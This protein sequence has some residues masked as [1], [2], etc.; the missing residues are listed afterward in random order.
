MPCMCKFVPDEV[1][2]RLANNRD[3]KEFDRNAL[4]RT[5]AVDHQMRHVRQAYGCLTISS[6]MI[7][8]VTSKKK[9]AIKVSDCQHGNILPGTPVGSPQS[10]KDGTVKRTYQNTADV[11][12]FYL[13]L[14][15]RNSVDDQGMDLISS[16]HYGQ[17]YNNAFW[18]GQQMIYGDGDGNIFID[19][20]RGD[21]VIGHELTHGVTQYTCQLDYTDEAGGLNESISDVF[22][23]MFRQ[24]Q[25][26]Q[27]VKTA[28]WLIGSDIIGPGAKAQ[29]YTCLRNMANPADPKALAAQPAQYSQYHP[30]MDPH[31]SSG[32]PNNAFYQAAMGIGGKSWE[33][34]GKIWYQALTGYGPSPQLTMK[35]FAD[36]TRTAA[37]QLFAAEPNVAKAVG[38]AW[39]AVGL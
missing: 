26:K 6:A 32:I 3:I 15:N 1:L 35:Q 19:F 17:D 16:V 24:W 2:A 27:T 4:Q 38:N 10:S 7:A 33:K 29:G 25:K 5:L 14:F 36:R 34:A 18:N 11:A 13:T 28:D 23:S 8:A 12:K 22:G 30:G 21:D 9:P 20:T 31:V 37:Q 39:V